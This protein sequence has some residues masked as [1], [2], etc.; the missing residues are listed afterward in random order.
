[1]ELKQHMRRGRGPFHSIVRRAFQLRPCETTGK[2]GSKVSILSA[3]LPFE[4]PNSP[5]SRRTWKD[6]DIAE[7]RSFSPR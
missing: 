2:N 1:M 7:K 6:D 5:P 3:F 4:L